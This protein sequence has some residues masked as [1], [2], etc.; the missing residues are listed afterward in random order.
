MTP[1]FLVTVPT[2]ISKI[3]PLHP[4]TPT[5]IAYPPHYRHEHPQVT[6]KG[7]T[8]QSAVSE[9]P[10]PKILRMGSRNLHFWRLPFF[11]TLK[12]ESQWAGPLDSWFRMCRG[13]SV[14]IFSPTC[15]FKPCPADGSPSPSSYQ[16]S[17]VKSLTSREI[18]GLFQVTLGVCEN[19]TVSIMWFGRL[20]LRSFI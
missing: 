15:S 14:A 1:P 2:A 17:W 20:G 12:C 10:Y 7:R 8:S 5:H 19:V 6:H 18:L 11:W 9:P 13:K 4:S 3:A 16:W